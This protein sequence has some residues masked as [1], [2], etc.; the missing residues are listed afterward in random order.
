VAACAAAELRQ[1]TDSRY[2]AY[3]RE[4]GTTDCWELD[5]LNPTVIAGLI[6]QEIEA[7][8]DMEAWN[9]ALNEET[10]NRS[11]L[12]LA[13]EHWVRVEGFLAEQEGV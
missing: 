10:R 12:S 11:M 3:V 4:F 2:A 6:G 13:S 9:L 5:A 7:L 1:G 8:V